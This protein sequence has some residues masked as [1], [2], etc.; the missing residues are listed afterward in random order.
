LAH[1]TPKPREK[2]EDGEVKEIVVSEESSDGQVV[3]DDIMQQESSS[4]P[5]SGCDEDGEELKAAQQRTPAID[6]HRST[7]SAQSLGN[8][9]DPKVWRSLGIDPARR[10]ALLEYTEFKQIFGI[11]RQKFAELPQW[12]QKEKKKAAW[13][14]LSWLYSSTQYRAMAT[15]DNLLFRAAN[16]Y[17][18]EA[19][20]S[21]EVLRGADPM[22][23]N[24][25]S[26]SLFFAWSAD[27]LRS[28]FSCI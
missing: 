5:C 3:S 14:V 22:A 2:D 11:S 13:L 25:R 17:A 15:N 21:H 23:G 10:E 27:T 19:D 8:L 12:R 24:T 20:L 16:S 1:E 28:P 6:M 26:R 9:R 18:Y 7:S 4:P